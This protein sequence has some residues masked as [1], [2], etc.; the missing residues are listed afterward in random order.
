V[1]GRRA[2]SN[3]VANPVLVGAVTLLVVVVAVF[4]AYNAN[5]GL[6]FVPTYELKVETP[7]AQR[8]VKGNEVREGGFRIG[9]VTQIDPVRMENGKMGAELTLALEK[10]AG[11]VPRDSRLMIRPRSTLGLKYVEL[12]RGRSRRTLPQGAT[13][14][15]T[16]DVA[17]P[18][19]DDLFETFTEDT[20]RDIQTNLGTFGAGFAGRGND[21]NRALE[22]FAPLLRDVQ[23]VMRTLS[24]PETRL[25]RFFEELQDTAAITVPVAR[26]LSSGFTAGADVFEAF[27]RD[28]GALDQTIARSPE[29]L[30]VGTP[31]L[32]GQRPFLRRFAGLSDELT[33][34]ARELRRSVT[35][36]S[37][38][39]R[40][41]TRSLPQ[42][43]ALSEDLGRTFTALRDLT[44]APTTNLV[45]EGLT[46]TSTT[47]TH[48]LRWL[49]PHVT[50]CNYW[51][52]WWT[53][54]ADHIA[55]EVDS[56]TVQRIQVKFA[57]PLQQN[58]PAE[59]GAREPA[60]GGASPPALPGA[61][62]LGDPVNL[63]AQPYG[64]AV[65]ERGEADCE[66]GQRGYPERLA[67]NLPSNLKIAVDPRTPGDQGPT[68][69]GKRRVPD[70]QTFTAEPGGLAPKVVAEP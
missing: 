13:L 18:E 69:T 57:N 51:N 9:Q 44:T 43:P 53:L 37:R 21:L 20:R 41:G 12:Q 70:G 36:V 24:A 1:S 6:P 17:P 66:T 23:P 27:S 35:P 5:S 19:L 58:N 22:A 52:Y 39:L 42:T 55:E 46:S 40:A 14:T 32:R 65:N 38:A 48:T 47:L 11:P 59:F 63:H 54:L 50:V 60:N 16:Q 31:A 29:T 15:A 64:R 30:R 33:G 49:G 45:L 3:I 10:D 4:L 25:V 28:P 56:G 61:P 26:E 8:L 7:N 2:A 67:K 62:S 68:F 34:T